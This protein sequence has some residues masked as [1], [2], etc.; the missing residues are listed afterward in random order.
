[1]RR[2]S[3]IAAGA[4]AAALISPTAAHAAER[5]LTFTTGAISVP[6]YGV[7]T[8]PILVESPRIDGYVVGMSA[9]IV[10]AGGR[11]QGR[12]RV[13]LHHV[14][15]GK[16][17]TPDLTCGGGSE[18]FYAEGEERMRLRLPAGYGYPNRATDRWYL[19]YMLMNHRREALTGFVRYTVRYVTGEALTPVRPLWLDV[20]NCTGPDPVFDVP[21]T[22]RRFS[23]YARTD[24]FTLPQSGRLVA[25]GGHVHGGG[26]RLELSN[27]TCRRTPFVSEPTWGGPVPRP[28]LHEPG[29]TKMSSFTSAEG[30][31][32][33]AGQRLQLRA[34]YDNGAPHARAM[35]IMLLYL[36][37]GTAAGCGAT[38][39]LH[40]DRGRPSYPPAFSFGLP[41]AP[42]GPLARDV[43]SSWVADYRYQH[44]RVSIPRGTRFT[45]RFTGSVPHDVTLVRGP[46]GFSAPWTLVGTFSRRFT[47]PGTYDLFC[48]LHPVRMSQRIVVR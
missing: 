20:R 29:P 7:A 38:P 24:S 46:E 27:A 30:I 37:P 35:G 3:L 11:V 45:W 8:K 17:G 19:L 15:F 26:I 5:T 13:M 31:P 44:E 36:A 28:I 47:R 18:R 1:V 9:E 21:G 4:L 40:V 22:G 10:D 6:A 43:R 41:R 12:D 48:S 39:P 34:V 2:T 32:V 42:G 33:A 25:G 16:L 23:T 14:V